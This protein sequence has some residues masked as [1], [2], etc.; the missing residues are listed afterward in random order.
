MIKQVETH[1][2]KIE[3]LFNDLTLEELNSLEK[4]LWKA[5][6]DGYAQKEYEVQQEEITE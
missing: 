4:L 6:Q 2:L 5:Y 1:L 3:R